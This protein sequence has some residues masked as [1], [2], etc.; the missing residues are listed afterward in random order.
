VFATKHKQSAD[1]TKIPKNF[2]CFFNTLAKKKKP[3]RITF[4]YKMPKTQKA[5]KKALYKEFDNGLMLH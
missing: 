4:D 5:P 2:H 3:V 1:Y